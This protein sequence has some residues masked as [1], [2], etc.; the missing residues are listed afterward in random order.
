M[1][2]YIK[3]RLVICINSA[4]LGVPTNKILQRIL[5][6]WPAKSWGNEWPTPTT[7]YDGTT[8][9]SGYGADIGKVANDMVTLIGEMEAIM[10][11][12]GMIKEQPTDPN[13][14]E[15]S[16]TRPELITAVN[17]VGLN[18]VERYLT[19][20]IMDSAP[21]GWLG[22]VPGEPLTPATGG[23]FGGSWSGTDATRLVNLNTRVT[24]LFDICKSYG[25]VV[26]I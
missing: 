16:Y 23:T 15:P 10:T 19:Q 14:P 9:G 17:T 13:Q 11:R 25:L 3:E 8:I 18:H 7:V 26:E 21:T 24:E 12:L 6:A 1:L 22:T 5:D 4:G 2:S 20:E